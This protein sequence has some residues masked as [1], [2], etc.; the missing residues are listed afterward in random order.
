M[1][2]LAVV[3]AALRL[4][5][6]LGSVALGLL[7]GRRWA[8]WRFRRRLARSGIPPEICA[9]LAESYRAMVRIPIPLRRWIISKGA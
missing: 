9:E 2:V 6:A 1:R 4:L 7:W 3:W 5:C 8:T